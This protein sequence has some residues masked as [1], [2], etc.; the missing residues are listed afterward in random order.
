MDHINPLTIGKRKKYMLIN[1]IWQQLYI[2][3]IVMENANRFL[4]Y[5]FFLLLR[6]LFNESMEIGF[7]T[8]TTLSFL[9][10]SAV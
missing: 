8:S 10:S 6:G 5:L 7:E 4:I 9:I 1:R 2:F 3:A